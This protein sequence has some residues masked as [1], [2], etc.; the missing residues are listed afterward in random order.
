MGIRRIIGILL[1]ESNQKKIYKLWDDSTDGKLS[2]EELELKLSCYLGLEMY[3]A[4]EDDAQE[5]AD[6]KTY[7]KPK[8]YLW[9]YW[10]RFY[11][12]YAPEKIYR[13]F[14]DLLRLDY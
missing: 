1:Y 5:Y 4:M 13:F 6:I 14:C 3:R 2:D 9:Y 7:N 8:N 12:L 11:K 10:I